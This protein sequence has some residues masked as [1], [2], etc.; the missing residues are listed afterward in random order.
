LLKNGIEPH[1]TIYHNDMPLALGL[2]P[3]KVNP[4]L[5]NERFVGWFAVLKNV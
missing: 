1:I 4:M 5:D 2:Y 3:N